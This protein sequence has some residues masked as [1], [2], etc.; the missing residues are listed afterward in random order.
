LR[1]GFLSQRSSF[2]EL[3][4]SARFPSRPHAPSSSPPIPP[5]STH[6]QGHETAVKKTTAQRHDVSLS[7][8]AVAAGSGASSSPLSH[9]PCPFS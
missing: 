5:L 1:P 9:T 2:H 7:I 6:C 8:R 4:P 3:R